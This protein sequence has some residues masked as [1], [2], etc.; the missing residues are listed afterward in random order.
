[1]HTSQ[2]KRLPSAQLGSGS[3]CLQC[4][5]HAPLLLDT[6]AVP[7]LW[8]PFQ[9]LPHISVHKYTQRGN[10]CFQVIFQEEQGTVIRPITRLGS[11]G[12]ILVGKSFFKV[13]ITERDLSSIKTP[14]SEPLFFREGRAHKGSFR[15]DPKIAGGCH[16]C[17]VLSFNHQIGKITCLGCT[18]MYKSRSTV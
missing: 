14:L 4:V 9:E 18:G 16:C 6:G 8:F 2:Q 15:A 11:K 12:Q 5:A 13:L 10:Y 1:M 7:A 17:T 3:C